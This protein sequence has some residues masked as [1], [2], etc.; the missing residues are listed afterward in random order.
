MNAFE[1]GVLERFAETLRSSR[2]TAK[3][4]KVPAKVAAQVE[5]DPA[6]V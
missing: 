2:S 5:T 4:A 3:R 1:D 6:A